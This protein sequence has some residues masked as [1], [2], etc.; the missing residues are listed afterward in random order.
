MK[1]FMSTLSFLCLIIGILVSGIVIAADV[2]SAADPEKPRRKMSLQQQAEQGRI[3]SK[4]LEQSQLE[5]ARAAANGTSEREQEILARQQHG[6]WQQQQ[7]DKAKAQFD[8]RAER[9]A[10]YL[11]QAKDAAAKER[12]ISEDE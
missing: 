10:K 7:R 11:Q 1:L 12:Q 9:E 2:I 4:K 8:E 3:D 5:K 6:E